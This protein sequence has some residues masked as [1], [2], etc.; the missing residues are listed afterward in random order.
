MK[1]WIG[2]A[3]FV[4]AVLLIGGTA[5]ALSRPAKARAV[6]ST[7]PSGAPAVGS[8]WQVDPSTAAQALPWGPAPVDCTAA[9]TVEIYYVGQAGVDLL[10]RM[11]AAKGDDV[12]VIANL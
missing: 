7:A 5:Y 2:I 1:R 8:C 11:D 4:V 6:P 9:H 10:H 12:K 3:V